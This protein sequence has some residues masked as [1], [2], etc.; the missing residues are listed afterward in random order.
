MLFFNDNSTDYE[1]YTRN[2]GEIFYPLIK[3]GEDFVM[4]EYNTIA[5][6]VR[7]LNADT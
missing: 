2:L 7:T 1:G 5:T 3:S 6:M 4:V